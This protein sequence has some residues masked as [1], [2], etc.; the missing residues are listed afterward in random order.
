MTGLRLLTALLLAA[1]FVLIGPSP[2]RAADDDAATTIVPSRAPAEK[3]PS[4][5]RNK[6]FLKKGRVEFTPRF[7]YISNNALNDEFTAGLGVTYHLSERLG[8]EASFDYGVIG[9]TQN[10]KQLAIAVL[11]LLDSSFRLESVDPAAFVSVSAIWSPMYGKINPFSSAVINLDF[12]FIF[13]LGYGNEH[14][15]ML[16]YFNDGVSEQAQLAQQSQINHLFMM[17][18]GFGAKV[19][20]TKWMSLRLDGRL[21]LTWDNVLNYDEDQAAATNRELGSLA[22]RLTCDDASI[23]ANEKACKT[24][25]PTTLVLSAGVSFWTPQQARHRAARK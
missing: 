3:S 21:Y 12:F 13:G 16:S 1:S 15:E 19:F 14:V 8:I 7:G 11:R 17:N 22:N 9:G 20:V 18:F 25:F 24:V 2:V 4:L 23:P 5:V 10:T 6:Y